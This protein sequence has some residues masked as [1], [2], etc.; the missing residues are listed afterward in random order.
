MDDRTVWFSPG[1]S[2]SA[3]ELTS[4]AR[5]GRT[6]VVQVESVHMHVHRADAPAYR[7]LEAGCQADSGCLEDFKEHNVSIWVV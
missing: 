3:P 2:S 6:W 7:L 1:P 4:L 5:S